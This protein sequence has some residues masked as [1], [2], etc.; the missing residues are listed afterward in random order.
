MVNNT[1]DNEISSERTE[2]VNNSRKETRL[3][4]YTET[5]DKLVIQNKQLQKELIETESRMD[6]LKNRLEESNVR[7]SKNLFY[8]GIVAVAYFVY[9]GNNH[10]NSVQ[11]QLVEMNVVLKEYKSE[12]EKTKLYNSL[13]EKKLNIAPNDKKGGQ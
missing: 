1:D 7:I 5:I 11:T 9:S 6:G 13:L 2:S 10:L 12:I 3:L 4:K 8:I